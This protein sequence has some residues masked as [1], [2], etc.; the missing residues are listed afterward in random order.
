M[1]DETAQGLNKPV[2][3]HRDIDFGIDD[4]LPKHWLDGCPHRTHFLNALSITFPEGE[5]FFIRSVHRFAHKAEDPQLKADVKAFTQQEAMHGREHQNLN[6]VLERQG[7]PVQRVEASATRDLRRLEKYTPPLFR[8]AVTACLEHYTALL[9]EVLLKDDS[10]LKNAE[11]R[12]QKMWQ[13]HAIEES[14][15]KAV[16]YDIYQLAAKSK[17]QAWWVR[18]FA[19]FHVT[20]RFFFKILTFYIWFLKEDKQL[21]K[22]KG[23]AIAWWFL[24]GKPGPLRKIIPGY[25]AW[26]KPGFHP[27]ERDTQE[28]LNRHLLDLAET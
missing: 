14:E 3:V 22:P 26:Y 25:F 8:L 11:P 13:W 4:T 20:L 16:A 5:R 28:L 6:D 19:M 24:F 27:L 2:I 18:C 17:W 9:A 7:Y 10:L 15:H 23:W 1:T 12:M 21:W